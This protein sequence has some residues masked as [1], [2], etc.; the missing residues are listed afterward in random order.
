[1]VKSTI[2]TNSPM[3]MHPSLNKVIALTGALMLICRMH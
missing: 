3:K 2:Q 1:M